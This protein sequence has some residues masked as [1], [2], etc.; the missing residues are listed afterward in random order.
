MIIFFPF[1]S[2]ATYTHHLEAVQ[3]PGFDFDGFCLHFNLYR[4]EKMVGRALSSIKSLIVVMVGVCLCACAS[5]EKYNENRKNY[6]I[7][8]PKTANVGEPFISNRVAEKIKGKRWV[9]LMNSNDGWEYTDEYTD[10]S[11][12]EDLIYTGH[13]G[14]VITVSYR[15]FQK[16]FARPAFFQSLKY[17]MRKSK[18]IVFKQY[19]VRVI[20]YNNESITFMVLSD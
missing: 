15:E 5:M 19:K 3:K 1:S 14:S 4:C 11:F 10:S 9:G 8:D 18:T 17:D 16:N 6:R 12:Q 2:T 13:E 20:D 7:N